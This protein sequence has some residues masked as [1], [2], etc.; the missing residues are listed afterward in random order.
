MDGITERWKSNGGDS[1]DVESY[2]EPRPRHTEPGRGET[3]ISYVSPE[4]SCR[5]VFASHEPGS[6]TR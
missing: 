6:L 3:R 4:P 2:S 5:V 1:I